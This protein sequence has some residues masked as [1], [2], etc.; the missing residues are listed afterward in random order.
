MGVNI[1][2][3]NATLHRYIKNVLIFFQTS[4]LGK[5]QHSKRSASTQQTRH[6]GHSANSA[7]GE[8]GTSKIRQSA[9]SPVCK[10]GTW[11]TRNSITLYTLQ[12]ETRPSNNQ[13]KFRSSLKTR[14]SENLAF[15]K[16]STRHPRQTWHW[17]KSANCQTRRLMNAGLVI[18]VLTHHAMHVFHHVT[19]RVTLLA[20]QQRPLSVKQTVR[21]YVKLKLY[22]HLLLSLH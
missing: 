2:K 3:C 16:L 7:L 15:G 18:V 9:I 22:A 1:N 21:Q 5:T 14:H 8:F 4:K 11:Q 20:S 10:F 19:P 6:S 12:S 17:A 13:Q